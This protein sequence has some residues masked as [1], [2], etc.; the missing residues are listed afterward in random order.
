L[1]DI[2]VVAAVVIAFAAFVTAHV[3]IVW[4]LLWKPPRWR[5]LVALVVVGGAPYWA[6]R[7]RMRVRAWIWIASAVVYLAARVAASL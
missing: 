5:A 4:G 3:A 2:I 1:R 7:E 6:L